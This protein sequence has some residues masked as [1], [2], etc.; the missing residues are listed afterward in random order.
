MSEGPRV[1]FLEPLFPRMGGGQIV[2]LWM[3]QA[4][5]GWAEPTLLS[6][7]RPDFASLDAFAGTDLAAAGIRVLRPSPGLRAFGDALDA[8]DPDPFSIQR[9]ALLERIARRMGPAYDILLSCSNERDMGGR[10]VQ[11]IHYPHLGEIH[12]EGMPPRLRRGQRWRPWRLVSG[13]EIAR[14]SANLTLANSDWT[15][16]RFGRIYGRLPETLYPPVPGDFPR[17]PW[18]ARDDAAICVGRIADDKRLD[19]I[20]AAVA[21]LRERHPGFRLRIAGTLDT[22][23]P[24]RMMVERAAAEHPWIELH[25][26]LPRDALCALMAASKIGIHAKEDEHFGI[27]VAE[28]LRAGCLTFAHDSGGQVEILG[29]APE[30]LF[31]TPDEAAG[32]MARAL[33]DDALR[34][35]LLAAL[36]ARAPLF[37]PERF[38][39]AFRGVLERFLAERPAGAAARRGAA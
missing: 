12:V 30:L 37:T 5:R 15:A 32:K 36:A 14:M 22:V 9:M 6:W 4:L 17:R 13:F 28:M 39:A 35:R 1:L 31:R 38:C 7:S 25:F 11:Y 27:A 24:A 8:L 19:R 16:E 21:A 20:I 33:A 10:G 34:E 2:G 23:A 3:L 29:R 26:D 18:A